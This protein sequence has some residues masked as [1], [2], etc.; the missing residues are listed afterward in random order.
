MSPE[1]PAGVLG[2]TGDV[3]QSHAR[4]AVAVT[5]SV[6]GDVNVNFLADEAF[7]LEPFP[8]DD[9]GP[10]DVRRSGPSSLLSTAARAV[11]FVGRQDELARLRSWLEQ[12]DDFSVLLLH[13]P[14][15][16]GK[17]R[18]AAQ[19][20]AR[21][22][23]EEWAV[24]QAH[25]H[26]DPGRAVGELEDRTVRG[27]RGLLVVADYAERWPRVHL[28]R[29]FRSPA[30]RQGVPVRLLLLARP[31]GYWWQSLRNPLSKLRATTEAL[32]L[33]PLA[34]T[35][36]DRRLMFTVARNRFGALLDAGVVTALEPAGSLTDDR[37]ALAL[38]LHMA[39]LVAVD[40]HRRGVR[41]P[42]DPAELSA[43]LLAR[44][45]DH[46][47][48]MRANGRVD[49]PERTMAR[50]AGLA[51]LTR[52]LPNAAAA[53][54]VTTVGL[55][56][57]GT[58]AQHL[59]DDHAVCYPPSEPGTMLE[60]LHPDRLGEDHVA[61]LLSG[62][63]G[64]AWDLPG[65]LLGTG[66]DGTR[67]PY[68]GAV[69]GVLVETAQRWERLRRDHLYPLLLAHPEL[70]EHAV[71]A[72]LVTLAEYADPDVLAALEAHLPQDANVELDTS[73]AVLTRRLTEY[74]LAATDDAA[75]RATLHH[76]LAVRSLHAGLYAE[77]VTAAREAVRLRDRLAA[78]DHRHAADLAAALTNLAIALSESDD[79]SG[80]AEAAR[81]SV[82]LRRR[83]AEE[84]SVVHEPDLALSLA[85]L[86]VFLTGVAPDEAAGAAREAVSLYQR[87][88][89]AE[90][91]TYRPDLGRA[92]AGLGRALNTTGD[93]RGGVAAAREAV[94]VFRPLAADSPAVHEP[95]LARSLTNLRINL[96]GLDEREETFALA[97]EA[98]AL[99]RRLAAANPAVFS[100]ESV[101][102][103]S[104]LAVH[105]VDHGR[106]DEALA[107]AQE[108]VDRCRDLVAAEGAVYEP[109]LANGLSRLAA[110]LREGR[111]L[112]QALA[113]D[114]EAV[115]VHRRLA[116][117]G[118]RRL[119][120]CLEGLAES[121]LAAARPRRAV[122]ALHEAVALHRRFGADDV[123]VAGS[124]VSLYSALSALDHGEEARQA[125]REAV[126][127]FR[128]AARR[129]PL[130]RID[131]AEA[132]GALADGLLAADDPGGA[133]AAAGEAA[134]IWR[135]ELD[136]EPDAWLPFAGCLGVRA[137]AL[138]A[139]GRPAEALGC[140]EE[141]V[142]VCRRADPLGEDLCAAL[143]QEVALRADL[144]RPEQALPPS[145]E[146][147]A[148]WRALADT[149]PAAHD[150]SL[151][152]ALTTHAELLRETG[153]PGEALRAAEEAEALWSTLAEEWPDIDEFTAELA[154]TRETL[155]LIRADLSPGG[156]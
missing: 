101:E 66:P 91:Q 10:P 119:A 83:L 153:D 63:D 132:L 125:L 145:A 82:A 89:T 80:A 149:D 61:A 42:E 88:A 64:W 8:L 1:P 9:P 54:V 84:N 67:P 128:A 115:A 30:L 131:L 65:R 26:T 46:W 79:A 156:G 68:T 23:A 35:V 154:G 94:A 52:P 122:S 11:P 106:T 15:G 59:L 155:K 96:S 38:T 16:Q 56:A 29:L 47:A 53:T 123:A 144:G 146:A 102:A 41:A 62:E 39:A 140:A 13:G 72:S 108:A 103:L 45:T 81:R 49:L 19:C 44:E 112:R 107:T 28:E 99:Y 114:T 152:T 33:G 55:A 86:S 34:H 93:L 27:A 92:W 148:G 74:G 139:L 90:P 14:G 22:A 110:A 51:T 18:L 133:A 143:N 76:R 60:P 70:V 73:I 126:T 138:V 69:L 7:W 50:M 5:G 21:A 87:L 118:S 121:L 141:R 151:A 97:V 147:V 104:A 95:S 120:A 37:Y 116:P 85:N 150:L 6:A 57:D 134:A 36:D 17:T 136:G 98:A 40:A 100:R 77:A 109:L 124:L 4:L 105:L 113:A 129:E 32:A 127:A 71:G 2:P 75:A 31:A 78:E 111:H 58:A 117:G 25:H 3:H 24:A 142:A 43:Y 135:S 48:T 12:E 130:Y 137:D 20:A